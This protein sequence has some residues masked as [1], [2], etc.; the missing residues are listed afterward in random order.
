[1]KT[2]FFCVIAAMMLLSACVSNKQVA[3]P[4]IIKEKL[5]V[6]EELLV[7]CPQLTFSIIKDETDCWSV[8]KTIAAQ[9]SKCAEKTNKLQTAIKDFNR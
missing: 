7:E 3:K 6:P 4:I 8:I 9:Y 1:M 2:K 5:L